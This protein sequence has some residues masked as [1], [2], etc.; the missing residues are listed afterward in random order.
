MY[1]LINR[2]KNISTTNLVICFSNDSLIADIWTNKQ[3]LMTRLS[4]MDNYFVIYVDQGMSSRD[5]KNVFSKGKISYFFNPIKFYND[6]LIN[7]SPYF[8]PLIKGG[9]IKRYSWIMLRVILNR[10][11]NNISYDRLI[12]WIYQPQSYYYFSDSKYIDGY[13][14]Y[15]CVDDFKSQPF[16]SSNQKRKN[17]LINIETK[18]IGNMDLITTTSHDL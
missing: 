17:E 15:D 10:I 11:I 1:Q 3:H 16:Y 18:L 2:I 12:Y 7:I 4:K 6:S 5:I 9:C 13:K 14:L 8:L